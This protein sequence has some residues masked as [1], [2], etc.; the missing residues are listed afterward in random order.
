MDNVVALKNKGSALVAARRVGMQGFFDAVHM[1][2]DGEARFRIPIRETDNVTDPN[3]TG[4][5]IA[6]FQEKGNEAGEAFTQQGTTDIQGLGRFLAGQVRFG[7]FGGQSAVVDGRAEIEILTV[8][9]WLC[10]ANG[11]LNKE[12]IVYVDGVG[13]TTQDGI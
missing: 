12:L 11:Q 2:T 4:L 1:Y 3:M 5:P 13:Q 6:H 10:C 7:F 8:A 9:G